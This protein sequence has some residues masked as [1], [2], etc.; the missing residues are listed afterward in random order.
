MA[1]KIHLKCFRLNYE[2]FNCYI[3]KEMLE[4]GMI[5]LISKKAIR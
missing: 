3:I 2:N 4:Q 1:K 5:V